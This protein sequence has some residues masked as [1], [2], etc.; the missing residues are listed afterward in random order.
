[1]TT[2]PTLATTATAS[3]PVGS[4][5]IT[6]SGALSAN[7]SISYV[8]GTLTISPAPLTITADDQTKVYWT[9]LPELTATYTGFVNGD[10]AAV[11]TTPPTLATAATKTS[12]VGEYPIAVGGAVG[13]DY[14]IPMSEAR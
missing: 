6:A 13:A 7:Y 10:T 9:P 5:P 12:P 4:Y 14:T 3:S 2:S 11:L 1:M 8:E